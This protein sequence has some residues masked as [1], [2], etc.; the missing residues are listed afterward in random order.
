MEQLFKVKIVESAFDSFTGEMSG[1]KFVNG[2]S[3]RSLAQDEV[4]KIAGVLRVNLIPVNSESD[5]ETTGTEDTD[6]EGTETGT[7]GTE[8]TEGTSAETDT[9]TDT[10]T[11]ETDTEN[12]GEEAK[13]VAGNTVFKYTREE[14]EA[15]ADAQGISGLREVA[16]QYNIKG[17]TI[18]DLMDKLLKIQK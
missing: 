12:T 9:E 13:S 4:A 8:G 17:K 5:E 3:V 1:L 6:T 18:N 16:N 2:L 7:E 14:L 15:L 11:T 10:E